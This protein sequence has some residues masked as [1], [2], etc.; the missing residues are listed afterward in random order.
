MGINEDGSVNLAQCECPGGLFRRH[1]MAVV[2][3][4]SVFDTVKAV[5]KTDKVYEWIRKTAPTATK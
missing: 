5:S 1:H 2:L 3:L 4:Y